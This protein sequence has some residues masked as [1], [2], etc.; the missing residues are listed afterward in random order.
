MLIANG[1]NDWAQN[2]VWFYHE[3]WFNISVINH[4]IHI[5]NIF[6]IK[7]IIAFVARDVC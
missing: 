1:D 3:E 2:I 5:T 7:N 6:S 4:K